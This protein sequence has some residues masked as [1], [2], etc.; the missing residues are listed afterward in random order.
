MKIIKTLVR[1]G[2]DMKFRLNLKNTPLKSVQENASRI[3]E[4][5]LTSVLRNERTRTIW[6]LHNES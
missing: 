1:T 4:M 5:C 3:S 2:I 6:D